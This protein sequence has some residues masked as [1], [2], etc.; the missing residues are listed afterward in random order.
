MYIKSIDWVDF[1]AQEAKILITDGFYE[2]IGY[3]Y[4]YD[5]HL[6]EILKHPLY[7]N[8]CSD[9]MISFNK[10]FFIEPASSST[11]L[12]Q[13]GV[14]ELIDISKN[15]IQIGNL[16][17]QLDN[18]PSDLKEGDYLEFNCFRLDVIK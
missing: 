9:V 15:L 5:F 18:I 6:G 14:G 8:S 3:S 13:K 17:I 12:H 2:C 1:P 4:G 7:A 16:L 10:E 11:N